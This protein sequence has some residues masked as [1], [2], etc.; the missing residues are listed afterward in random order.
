MRKLLR[1]QVDALDWAKDRKRI[2]LFMEMRLGKTLIAIR[3]VLS[4]LSGHR[5]AVLVVAPLSVCFVWQEEL[6]KEGCSSCILTG[7]GNEKIQLLNDEAVDWWITNYEALSI[8]RKGKKTIP[9]FLCECAWDVV[10]LDESTAIRKPLAIRTK[11]CQRFLS[12]IKYKAILTG[13]PNPEGP[14]DFFEQL[15]FLYGG[16]MDCQNYWKFR[17]RYFRPGYM[18]WDWKPSLRT[19]ASIKTNVHEQAF[20]LTQRQAGIGHRFVYEKRYV[21]LPSKLQKLYEKAEDEFVLGEKETKWIIVVR[22][23]LHQLCGG[24]ATGNKSEVATHKSDELLYLLNGEF[25][26]QSV[27]VWFRFNREIEAI[28]EQL[29]AANVSHEVITGA[30][31]PEVREKLRKKFNNRTYRVLLVQI[32]CGKFGIDFSEASTCIFYSNSFEY[33]ERSQA[34]QR[35]LHPMKKRALLVIDLITRF[36]IEEDIYAALKMKKS[37]ARY[38]QSRFIE[39]LKRRRMQK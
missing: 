30:T 8:T 22:G 2:A 5:K 26:G 35:I 12:R 18:G 13:L 32:K 25:T 28:Q 10:I 11:F 24:F 37:N 19:L 36:T 34:E 15:R 4:F 27:I 21:Y 1:H 9:S 3:W 16:F 29:V 23:W 38:F 33:E 39:N 6:A 31:K 17:Q 20:V 7:T 14:L